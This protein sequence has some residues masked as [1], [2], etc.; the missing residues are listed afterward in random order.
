M[1]NPTFQIQSSQAVVV[2]LADAQATRKLG[3]MLG[4]FLP[5]GSVVL[6]EGELGA[7]KTT[8]VQGIGEGLGIKDLIDSPTFTLINEYYQGR[9]PLYHLDLYRLQGGEIEAIAP[10]IYWEGVE[11]TPGITAIEWSQRLSYKPPHYLK[12]QLVDSVEQ[13]RYANITLTNA[14]A[15]DLSILTR[16]VDSH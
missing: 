8:L 1:T 14:L 10:E 13:G 12:I 9:L 4:E 11:V 6:L 3:R 16:C 5:A 15:F 2:T 7:G